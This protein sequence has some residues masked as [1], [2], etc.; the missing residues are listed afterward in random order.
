MTFYEALR[1]RNRT[2][3]LAEL[4]ALHSKLANAAPP[5]STRAK[6]AKSTSI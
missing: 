1:A 2:D 3:L 4:E 5:V 6:L